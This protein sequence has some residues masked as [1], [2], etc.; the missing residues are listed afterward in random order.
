MFLN[1][2]TCATRFIFNFNY[3][4]IAF[5]FLAFLTYNVWYLVAFKELENDK[6]T[7][8]TFEHQARIMGL[9][10]GLGLA[11]FVTL[12]GLAMSV[13]LLKI[14]KI[15]QIV[16]QN[17]NQNIKLDWNVIALHAALIFLIE[18]F[19]TTYAIV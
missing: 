15:I 2:E 1:Q 12:V 18:I 5:F 14:H 3:I 4:G 7:S 6:I 9:C 10:Y 11:V 16:K 17:S 13:A 19:T 8:Q